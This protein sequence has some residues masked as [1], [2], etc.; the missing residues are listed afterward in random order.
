MDK[1]TKDLAQAVRKELKRLGVGGTV[2]ACDRIVVVKLTNYVSHHIVFK[3][4]WALACSGASID[5]FRVT[6]AEEA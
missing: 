6:F 1:R 2:R 5:D 3:L 4:A